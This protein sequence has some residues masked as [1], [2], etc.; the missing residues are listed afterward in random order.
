MV[1]KTFFLFKKRII[2]A[3][4]DGGCVVKLFFTT[5]IPKYQSKI[6]QSIP[7]KIRGKFYVFI[8]CFRIL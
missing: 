6:R 4:F 3:I 5:K 1:G 7:Q 8:V 2:M